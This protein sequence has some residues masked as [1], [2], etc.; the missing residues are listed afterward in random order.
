MSVHLR[1]YDLSLRYIVP[2]RLCSPIPQAQWQPV[3]T[4]E[5]HPHTKI[6]SKESAIAEYRPPTTMLHRQPNHHR[7]RMSRNPLTTRNQ[8]SSKRAWEENI[9]YSS[10]P[11][12]K[13]SEVV[14]EAT[15]DAVHSS[16]ISRK[17][18]SFSSQLPSYK[19]TTSIRPSSSSSTTKH[20]PKKM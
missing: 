12:Y 10:S 17:T 16:K 8:I 4:I 19:K 20:V 11:Q 5:P 15:E 9:Q 14:N 13:E 7:N 6:S 1:D 3:K 18:V 2:S